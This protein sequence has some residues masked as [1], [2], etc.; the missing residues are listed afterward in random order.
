[1]YVVV[2]GRTCDS[3]QTAIS[4]TRRWWSSCW[5]RVI[6]TRWPE[7][8]VHA[9]RSATRAGNTLQMAQFVVHSLRHCGSLRGA[10]IGKRPAPLVHMQRFLVG[11]TGPSLASQSDTASSVWTVAGNRSRGCSRL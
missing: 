9:V 1:M 6:Y 8:A 3:L 5:R 10:A 11:L 2:L 7:P 4:K